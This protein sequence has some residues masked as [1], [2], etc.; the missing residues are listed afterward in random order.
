MGRY[1]GVFK[2][3][4]YPISIDE[5]TTKVIISGMNFVILRVVP[6]ILPEI[7]YDGWYQNRNIFFPGLLF[8]VYIESPN[9]KNPEGPTPDYMYLGAPFLFPGLLFYFY[10]ESPNPKNPEGPTLQALN[11]I[12]WK[13]QPQK[14]NIR[15]QP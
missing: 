11:P 7:R 2:L 1:I 3:K 4:S 15:P 14:P 6:S 12:T 5:G 8:Y 10:I 9:P 13:L